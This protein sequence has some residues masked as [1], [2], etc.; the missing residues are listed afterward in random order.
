M[1]ECMNAIQSSSEQ[2]GNAQQEL[3]KVNLALVEL[4]ET[5]SIILPLTQSQVQPFSQYILCVK[6]SGSTISLGMLR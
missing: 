5:L 4:N 3:Q 1:K 2:A 6:N